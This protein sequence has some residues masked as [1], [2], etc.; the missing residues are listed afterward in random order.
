MP[1]RKCITNA[2]GG[3]H[4]LKWIIKKPACPL[5]IPK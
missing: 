2:G 4:C 1:E 5:R 3:K